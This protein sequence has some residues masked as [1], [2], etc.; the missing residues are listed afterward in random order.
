MSGSGVRVIDKPSVASGKQPLAKKWKPVWFMTAATVAFLILLNLTSRAFFP[1][2]VDLTS[3][4]VHTLSPQT[5]SLLSTLEQPFELILLCPREPKSSSEREFTQAAVM[6]RELIDRYSQ[7]TPMILVHD[8]DPLT[9]SEGRQ[10]LQLYP[11]LSPPCV[12]V[13]TSGAQATGHELLHARDLASIRGSAKG[14]SPVIEFF[15]EQAVTAALARLAGGRKQTIAYVV[16]GHGE[17]AL[18]DIDPQSRHGLGLLRERL[19]EL[20]VE[21][22]PLD[23]KR[24]ERVP[25]DADFV[26][27]AGGDQP[28]TPAEEEALRR[29]WDHG[30]RGL[31]LCELNYDARDGSVV[32][33]GLKGLLSEYGVD[34]GVDRA[35]QQS[36]TGVIEATVEGSPAVDSHPLVR[37]LPPAPVRLFECRSVRQDFGV[38]RSAL[39]SVPLLVSPAS[40]EAWADADFSVGQPPAPDGPDDLPGPVP[41]ALA[42]ERQQ[43]DLKEPVLVV[44]GD[45]EFVDNQSLQSPAGRSGYSFILA[46]VNWLHGRRGLMGDIAVRR[47][48]GYHLSGTAAEQRGL[49]WKP[50]LLMSSLLI[51]AAVSVWLSRRNG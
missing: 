35:L 43:G 50:T 30:G 1:E 20:D 13:R 38:S 40:P 45:A 51:T 33:T 22:A 16:T 42:I 26:V 31:V 15:G 19:R 21:L 2:T 10:L 27:I 28:L 18:D 34:L 4:G 14:E 48:E 49:V 6:L 46:C 32:E 11:D 9:S 41:L 3:R 47:T 23:L 5:V 24:A 36:V 12:L 8:A 29:Y 7:I 44:V 25:R 39:R 17:L 37:S